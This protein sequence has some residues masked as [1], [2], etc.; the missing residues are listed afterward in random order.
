M[1]I[2][3]GTGLAMSLALAFIAGCADN[4]ATSPGAASPAAQTTG[5]T[6]TCKESNSCKGNASCA[7]VAVNEKHGCKGQNSCA[8]NVR[9]VSK[10]ECDKIHGTV[11]AK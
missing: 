4:T 8:A 6:V 11:A 1:N 5:A 10:E 3:N 7:G 2:A 9:E